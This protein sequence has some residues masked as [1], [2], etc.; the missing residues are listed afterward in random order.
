[1]V[2]KDFLYNEDLKDIHK[3]FLLYNFAHKSTTLTSI[4]EGAYTENDFKFDC[5][6]NFLLKFPNFNENEFEDL[7]NNTINKFKKLEINIFEDLGF[8]EANLLFS[9]SKEKILNFIKDKMNNLDENKQSFLNEILTTN[10]ENTKDYNIEYKGKDGDFLIIL[11]LLF[12]GMY[13]DSRKVLKNI[14]YYYFPTYFSEIR[15]DLIE[16]ID[17][18]S[19]KPK[20]KIKH[21]KKIPPQKVMGTEEQIYKLKITVKGTKGKKKFKF[22]ISDFSIGAEFGEQEQQ[23]IEIK[24]GY[25]GSS[26]K[27]IIHNISEK[28]FKCAKCGKLNKPVGKDRNYFE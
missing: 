4:R 21:K 15:L 11:G 20:I 22:G 6:R 13:Y 18:K 1:M 16:Y 9:I 7:W 2:V 25:C 14:D 8:N 23:T 12:K 26:D 5:K 19:F 24:C 3:V 27:F 28:I 10:L 17:R